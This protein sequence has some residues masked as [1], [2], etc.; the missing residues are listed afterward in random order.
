[1]VRAFTD[2]ECGKTISVPTEKGKTMSESREKKRR[3][4]LRLE[5]ISQFSDWLNSEPPIWMFK[6]W[7]KW[8]NSKPV[9]DDSKEPF[10]SYGLF[11]E[12]G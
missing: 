1:M 5:Y 3:Y 8:K 6:K 7:R 11:H 2:A 4:N 12:W 10:Y 9:W